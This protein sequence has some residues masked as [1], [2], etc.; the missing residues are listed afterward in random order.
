MIG[1]IERIWRLL[2]TRPL[3]PLVPAMVLVIGIHG[4]TDPTRRVTG[5]GGVIPVPGPAAP[6][7]ATTGRLDPIAD[8][9][10]RDARAVRGRVLYAPGRAPHT[11]VPSRTVHKVPCPEQRVGQGRATG[12]SP[13][14]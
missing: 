12:I 3:V 5:Y 9:Q 13:N 14:S 11:V 8:Q 7:P 10:H 1:S 2:T 6:T 4:P